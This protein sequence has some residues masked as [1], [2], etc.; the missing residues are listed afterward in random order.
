[1]KSIGK[2]V[3]EQWKSKR[4]HLR[5]HVSGIGTTA[6]AELPNMIGTMQLGV[7]IDFKRNKRDWD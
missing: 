5:H 2:V 7:S 6:E 3:T 4:S 1:M